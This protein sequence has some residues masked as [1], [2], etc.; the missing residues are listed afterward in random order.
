MPFLNLGG[1]EE[2]DDNEE[3]D[4]QVDD[5]DMAAMRLLALLRGT[6]L[7]ILST[8]H[9]FMILTWWLL[10]GARSGLLTRAQVATLLTSNEMGDL[11]NWDHRLGLEAIFGGQAR[12]PPKDPTR[13]PK[14]PSEEGSQLMRSGAFGAN[15]DPILRTKKR[16]ARR[17]LD[18]ELGVGDGRER[19]RNADVMAQV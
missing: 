5:E 6:P 17:L 3:E 15:D 13:F 7:V 4:R 8:L 14:V 9:S 16:V 18:R 12:G 11:S 2:D 19:T 1:D 10:A